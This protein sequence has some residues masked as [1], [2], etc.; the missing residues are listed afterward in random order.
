MSQRFTSVGSFSWNVTYAGDT[1]N[2]A[3]STC[4]PLTVVQA[5]PTLATV[6][7]DPTSTAVTSITVGTAAH[8]TATLTNGF[9][10][11]GSL[12]Y[13]I[14]G[15][16]ACTATGTTVSTVTVTS[17]VV[18]DSAAT[19]PSSAGSYSF[20]A[21]YTGDVNN[22]PATSPCEPLTVISAP[23]LRVDSISVSPDPASP[24]TI[25]TKVTFNVH[26]VNNGTADENFQIWI[27]WGSVTVTNQTFSLAHGQTQTFTLTWDTA[28]SGAAT[29]TISAVVP[30]VPGETITADN[31]LQGPSLTL[32]APP[33]P[34]FSSLINS[35]ALYVGVPIALI[36]VLVA[37]YLVLRGRKTVTA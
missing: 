35:P 22:N 24:I 37:L 27:R 33:Q 18:P 10:A 1:N 36:I 30:P 6:V 21:S 20:Q 14:F 16:N 29:N 2:N 32:E 4:E 9:Q 23:N 11:G 28:G 17:G 25:G 19:T 8:D 3:A 12:T 34:L 5:S 31:T 13:T 15:N 7:K 26:I